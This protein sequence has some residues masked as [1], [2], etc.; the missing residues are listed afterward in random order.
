MKTFYKQTTTITPFLA[1]LLCQNLCTSSVIMC[2]THISY[3]S[4][5]YEKMSMLGGFLKEM[6]SFLP[7]SIISSEK[8]ETT[9]VKNMISIRRHISCQETVKKT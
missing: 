9:E 4:H 2:I 8:Y 6:R 7:N 3:T 1:Q 5:H